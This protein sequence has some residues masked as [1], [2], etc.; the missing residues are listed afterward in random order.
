MREHLL[1]EVSDAIFELDGRGRITWWNRGAERALGWTAQE[2]VGRT[3]SRLLQPDP[4]TWTALRRAL[5]GK[6]SWQG[7]LSLVHRSGARLAFAARWSQ[8]GE[9]AWGVHTEVTQRQLTLSHFD[10]L[11]RLESLA[12]VATGLAH[13]LNN[14]LAPILMS[15]GLLQSLLPEA[16]D[17]ELAEIIEKSGQRGAA[18]VREV[19]TFA[20]ALPAPRTPTQLETVAGQVVR[21][22]RQSFP[23]GLFIQAALPASTPE[24]LSDPVQLHQLVWDQFQLAREALPEEGTIELTIT[25]A[26]EELILEL[27]ARPVTSPPPPRRDLG[28]ATMQAQGGSAEPWQLDGDTLVRRLRWPLREDSPPPLDRPAVGRGEL[29]RVCADPPLADLIGRTLENW[30][31]RVAAPD[32]EAVAAVGSQSALA[33]LDSGAVKVPLPRPCGPLDLLRGLEKALR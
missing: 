30:G 11:R 15:A 31:Y 29:I 7:E 24:I 8:Q 1:D 9:T 26:A 21:A 32:D 16:E 18:L 12:S 19:Q 27:T 17:R 13:D 6:G 2:A 23:P 3:A 14:M 28:A 4:Q 25:P 5:P 33:E 10:R 20:R 22:C